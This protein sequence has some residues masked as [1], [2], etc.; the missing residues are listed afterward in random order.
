MIKITVDISNASESEIKELN[1][2]IPF[3]ENQFY[4]DK[5]NIKV[6]F[7]TKKDT[8]II[9]DNLNTKAFLKANQEQFEQKINLGSCKPTHDF[10]EDKLKSTLSKI[11]EYIECNFDKKVEKVVVI[12]TDAQFYTTYPLDDSQNER[13]MDNFNIICG[14]DSCSNFILITLDI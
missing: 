12:G 5:N 4:F 9:M 10:D 2:I 11:C 3:G 1:K 14:V 8:E 13:L 7:I 6:N